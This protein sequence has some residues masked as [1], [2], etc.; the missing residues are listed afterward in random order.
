MNAG[1]PTNGVPTR[2]IRHLGAGHCHA[3]WI[4]CA[5]R[6]KNILTATRAGAGWQGRR[7]A[8]PPPFGPAGRT[9]GSPR[10]RGGGGGPDQGPL[11]GRRG[12]SRRKIAA[13]LRRALDG[14]RHARADHLVARE[15]GPAGTL[16]LKEI[17]DL[18]AAALSPDALHVGLQHLPIALARGPASGC[19]TRQRPPRSPAAGSR[20]PWR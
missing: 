9:L 15:V 17:A 7:R 10:S 16:R 12:R 14:R 4:R 18:G 6:V 20:S 11:V 13:R 1:H 19:R 5:L 8:R 3:A 2:L